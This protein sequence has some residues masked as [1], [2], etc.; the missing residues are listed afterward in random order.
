VSVWIPAVVPRPPWHE[1]VE[2]ILSETVILFA[3]LV[4]VWG[5]RMALNFTL[6]PG[7]KLYGLIPVEW[8]TDTGDLVAFLRYL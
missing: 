3:I 1:I 4:A 7:A 6:G 5:I 2:E 8:I